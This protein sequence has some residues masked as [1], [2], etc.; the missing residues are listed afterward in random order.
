MFIATLSIIA[1]EMK[2]TS[3]D[4]WINT[5]WYVHTMAYYSVKKE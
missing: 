1:K 3:T 5:K 2:C 4:E